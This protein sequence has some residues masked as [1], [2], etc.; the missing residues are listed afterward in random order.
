[1]TVGRDQCTARGDKKYRPRELG[2]SLAG[3]G[4]V[5]LLP[6]RVGRNK[7]D[8]RVHK[9]WIRVSRIGCG[10]RIKNDTGVRSD[11]VEGRPWCASSLFI[12]GRQKRGVGVSLYM[13]KKIVKAQDPVDQGL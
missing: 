11:K 2:I 7:T 13:R 6:A 12:T 1:M 8:V 4:T 10:W 5:A 3:S 9:E